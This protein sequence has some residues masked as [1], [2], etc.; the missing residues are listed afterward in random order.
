MG[1]T[2]GKFD[3]VTGRE[4]HPEDMSTVELSPAKKGEADW[5]SERRRTRKARYATRA[6]N[7]ALGLI[8]EDH[9]EDDES[10]D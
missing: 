10:D 5:V 3:D 1:L 6:M 4:Q 9:D 2:A 8:P 7:C